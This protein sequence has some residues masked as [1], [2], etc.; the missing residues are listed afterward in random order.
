MFDTDRTAGPIPLWGG[1]DR[2]FPRQGFDM[3]NW[4]TSLRRGAFWLAI[5]AL[6]AAGGY[7][8]FFRQGA[9]TPAGAD[10]RAE[11]GRP[12]PVVTATV[13][14]GKVDVYLNGLGTVTPTNTVTVKSRVDGQ[15]MRVLFREGQTV[16][17]GQLLAEIDPRPFQAQLT[18]A[19]GQLARDQALL[20]NARLDL[21]RYR[22]LYAQD[23]TSQQQL[24]TQ[25]ALVQQY[26]GTVKIDQGAV[27][28]ARLQLDYTRISAPLAGRVGL[29]QVDPGNIVHA[30]DATGLVVITQEQ[31]IGVVFSLPEDDLPQVTG[32][33]N[34]GATLPVLAYDRDG[35]TRL[36]EGRLASVDNQID[37]TTG[38]VKLKA[39]FANR[40]GSLF[41]NQFV[42]VRLQ[43]ATL[44]DAVLAPTAAIQHGAQGSYLYVV[45]PDDTATVRPVKTGPAEHGMTAIESGLAAGER[46]VLEG[47]DRLREGMKVKLAGAGGGA[48]NGGKKAKRA[49]E[50]Q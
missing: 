16:K 2:G 1:S 24:A 25:Q 49:K 12:T 13:R 34:K 50:P 37:T 32:P 8:L 11:R 39:S 5:L 14:T 35:Q 45:K 29:R 46:V 9:E 40:D 3:S 38:T 28:N 18:Q 23:S 26:E 48:Q 36:A 22:T 33:L 42:N 10:R 19:E 20:Q 21:E 6:L 43:V 17:A 7:Y 41:P 44:R 47:T 31:P 15:L 27:A 4:Q 30:S